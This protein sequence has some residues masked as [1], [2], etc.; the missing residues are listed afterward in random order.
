[1]GVAGAGGSGAG[2]DGMG[3]LAGMG[4]SQGWSSSGGSVV[5][6]GQ[7]LILIYAYILT[8]KGG[9]FFALKAELF[10]KQVLSSQNYKS[11]KIRNLVLFYFRCWSTSR[12]TGRGEYCGGRGH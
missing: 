8:C 1:M 4:S 6:G 11:Q 5:G 2:M 10:E 9:S 12:Y 3:P 7:Y